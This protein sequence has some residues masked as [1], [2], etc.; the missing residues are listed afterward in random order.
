MDFVTVSQIH[1]DRP[2]AENITHG[3]ALAGFTLYQFQPP[4]LCKLEKSQAV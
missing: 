1:N 3:G 4:N 2:L